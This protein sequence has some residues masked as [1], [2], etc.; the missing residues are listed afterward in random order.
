MFSL[1]DLIVIKSQLIIPALATLKPQ[2]GI[3]A[4]S[5][6]APAAPQP[7]SKTVIV[8]TCCV[9]CNN[10]GHQKVNKNINEMIYRSM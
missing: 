5:Y 10:A 3:T 1:A 9:T 6:P 4:G 7:V 2:A 8:V